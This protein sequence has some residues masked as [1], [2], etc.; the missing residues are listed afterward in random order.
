MKQIANNLIFGKNQKLNGVI[1]LAFV[2][3]IALGCTCNKDFDFANTSADATTDNGGVTDGSPFGDDEETN[4]GMPDD[5]LL[6]ALVKSTT[7]DFAYAISTEDFSKM[8]EKAS[9]DFQNTYTE[10][11]MEEFFADFMKN[12]RQLLPILAKTVS[13]DPEF[14]GEPYIRTE[15]G[16]SILVVNGK[17]VTKPVPLTFN[18]EYVKRGGQWKMLV[19]KVFLK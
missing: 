14:D 2:A 18:Y 3:L 4:D 9:Q 12:K 5:R 10:E 7:A 1:A 15:N 6:M 19:L 16:L 8:Y 17:Y 13:S 11:Q